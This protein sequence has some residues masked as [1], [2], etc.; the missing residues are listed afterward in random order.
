M[1]RGWV[2]TSGYYKGTE[3]LFLLTYLVGVISRPQAGHCSL[4]AMI[5]R[6]LVGTFGVFPP[7][8][9]IYSFFFVYFMKYIKNNKE[10]P[11]LWL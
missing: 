8:L 2:G 7:S 10:E 11:H 3:K 5:V 6:V 4:I 1:A 9:F